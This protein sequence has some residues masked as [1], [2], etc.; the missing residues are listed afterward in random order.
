VLIIGQQKNFYVYG[1]IRRPGMYPMEDDLNIVRV[2]SIGGGVTERG[3][4]SKLLFIENQIT[5]S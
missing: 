1:E 3:S 4:A 5:E 2:L